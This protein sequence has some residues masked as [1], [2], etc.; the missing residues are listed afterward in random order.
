[1]KMLTGAALLVAI[2]FAA[3][4]CAGGHEASAVVSGRNVRSSARVLGGRVSCTAIVGRVVRPRTGLLLRFT[5]RNVSSRRVGVVIDSAL[6]VDVSGPDGGI[7]GSRPGRFPVRMRT[8]IEPGKTM[9]VRFRTAVGYSV[10]GDIPPSPRVRWLGP[11]S[12]TPHCA[13]TSLPDLPVAVKAS[14]LS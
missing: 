10:T 5:L 7:L 6:E 9:T 4:A 2:T 12:V 14:R 3:A 11:L 13:G 1:M 8:P